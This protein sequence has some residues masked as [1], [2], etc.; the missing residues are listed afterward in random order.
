MRLWWEYRERVGRKYEELDSRR[1]RWRVNGGST[2]MHSFG[3]AEEL[4]GRT[5]GESEVHRE[6]ETKD[7]GRRRWRRQW[8]RSGKHGRR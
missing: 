4:C 8:G 1:E 7:G 2:R 3:V 5:S 6:A